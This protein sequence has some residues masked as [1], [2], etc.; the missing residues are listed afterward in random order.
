MLQGK[1]PV[2]ALL[3]E[4]EHYIDIADKPDSKYYYKVIKD[5]QDHLHTLLFAH[6]KSIKLLHSNYDVLLLNCTYKTN[7]FHKPLLHISGIT[8]PGTSF[9]IAYCFLPNEQEPSYR[10]VIK[11]LFDLYH[12]LQVVPSIFITVKE[13]ALKNALHV[14]WPDLPQQLCLW[15][16]F[17]NVKTRAIKCWDMVQGDTLDKKAAIQKEHD[18]F[19]TMMRQLTNVPSPA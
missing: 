2:Q 10:L 5:A 14:Y 15:H 1:T 12:E 7:K 3:Q 18:Q 4:L 16:I 6:P 11:S 17:N 8:C 19:L 13:Q 9:E